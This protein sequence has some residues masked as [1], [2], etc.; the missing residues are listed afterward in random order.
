MTRTYEAGQIMAEYQNILHPLIEDVPFVLE[1][2]NWINKMA[3]QIST[4]VL[5]SVTE[6]PVAMPQCYD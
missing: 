1:S 3:T 2:H 4:H 6:T 5:P